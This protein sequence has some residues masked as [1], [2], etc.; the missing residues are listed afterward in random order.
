MKWEF[1]K[2]GDSGELVL[3]GEITNRS[4]SELRPVL[5]QSLTCVNRLSL[6]LEDIEEVDLS[7]LQLLCSTHKTASLLMKELTLVAPAPSITRAVQEAGFFSHSRCS[8]GTDESC[9]WSAQERGP[10]GSTD[11]NGITPGR[12]AS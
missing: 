8:H 7:L 2:T 1:Q 11:S 3:S 10:G 9:F 6:R 5:V 4:L 12:P